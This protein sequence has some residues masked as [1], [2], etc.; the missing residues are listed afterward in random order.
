MSCISII[1]LFF[2]R[3][4][5]DQGGLDCR[6]DWA[7]LSIFQ[8]AQVE[9]NTMDRRGLFSGQGQLLQE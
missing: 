1:L 6:A 9:G 3:S 4:S 8:L 5:E 2:S 7:D